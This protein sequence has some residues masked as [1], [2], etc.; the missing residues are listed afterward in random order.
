MLG[1]SVI[2]VLGL[3]IYGGILF[4]FVLLVDVYK[5]QDEGH[6]QPGDDAGGATF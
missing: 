5:R 1:A 2:L 3:L 4:L 6:E